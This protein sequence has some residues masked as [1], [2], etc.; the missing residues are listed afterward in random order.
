LVGTRDTELAARDAT[1]Q[2]QNT[3]LQAQQA[4]N[5]DLRQRLNEQ[6]AQ[7]T[8]LQARVD[9]MQTFSGWLK[10]PVRGLR[11]LIRDRK[12]AF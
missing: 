9:Y 7:S 4:E 8:T 6:I 5:F 10:Q 1:I 2:A 11:K 12:Q 3:H